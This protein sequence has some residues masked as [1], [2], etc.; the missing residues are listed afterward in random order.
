MRDTGVG[1]PI[2]ELPHM[3]E[4]FHR[5]ED[6]RGRTYEGTG[7][8]LAL[9]QELVKLHGGT[10]QVDSVLGEGSTFTATIPLGTAHLDPQRIGTPSEPALAGIDSSA[11]VEEALRWLPSAE[12]TEMGR[13]RD[14]ESPDVLVSG[15]PGL[16]LVSHSGIPVSRARILWADDN[17][18]MREYVNQLLSGHF[19]VQAVADGQAALEAAARQA[20]GSGA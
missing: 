19:D 15:S 7:I 9:V 16:L 18:D 10:V 4:R 17:A 12:D 3:F 14:T 5:V 6:S 13:Q 2:D 20:A 11:F 1:I 8:G